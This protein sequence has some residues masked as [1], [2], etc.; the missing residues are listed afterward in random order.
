MGVRRCHL[1]GVR[2]AESM[3]RMSTVTCVM[4]D[5][6]ST[7]LFIVLQVCF[8]YDFRV[9]IVLCTLFDLSLVNVFLGC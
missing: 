2:A 3:Y 6:V 4:L 8:L 1:V 5:S 9:I 7:L